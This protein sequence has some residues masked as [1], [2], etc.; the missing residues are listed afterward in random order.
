MYKVMNLKASQG[1][2]SKEDLENWASSQNKKL[3][4]IQVSVKEFLGRGDVTSFKLTHKLINSPWG[5][6][7]AR[8]KYNRMRIK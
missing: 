2:Y 1:L 4:W 3:H 6:L 5:P 7:G 8:S